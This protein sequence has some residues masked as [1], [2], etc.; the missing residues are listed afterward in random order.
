MTN[1]IGIDI[2]KCGFLE[3]TCNFFSIIPKLHVLRNNYKS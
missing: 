2:S 1:F 3:I